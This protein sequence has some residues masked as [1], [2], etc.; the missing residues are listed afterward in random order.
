VSRHILVARHENL[1]RHEAAP[2]AVACAVHRTLPTDADQCHEVVATR[3]ELA[4]A[5]TVI[6]RRNARHDQASYRTAI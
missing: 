5:A 4:D 6:D 1:D 2:F 3:D